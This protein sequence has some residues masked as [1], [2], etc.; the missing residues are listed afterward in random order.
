MSRE[1]KDLSDSMAI[2]SYRDKIINGPIIRMLLWLGAP[3]LLNQLI[4]MAYNT[5]D[6]YWLSLCSDLIVAVPRQVWPIMMLFQALLNALTAA[7]LSMTSQYI[8]GKAYK[9]ASHSV[10][11][12]FTISFFAGGVLCTIL[13][14]LR[15]FI[16]AWM[17]TPHEIFEDVMRYS[18]IIAFDIFLNY[19]SLTFTTILQSVGDTKRPAMINA[20]SVSLNMLLDPFLVLGLGP[21][22]RLGVIGASITDVMG[23]AISTILLAYI[24]RRNYP[25]LKITFTKNIDFKW[26]ILVMH[27]SLPVLVLG[28]TNSFAFLV[29]LKIVNNLGLIAATAYA[30]GFIIMDIVDGVLFGLSGATAIMV[31]QNLGAR[32]IDRAREVSY[33]SALL[34]F[35]LVA[36]GASII[37]PVRRILADVFADDPLIIAETERFLQTLLPTLPFFGLF[38]VAMSTG[39]GSGHTLAPTAIGI[40]RLWGIRIGLGYF[41]AFT[42]NMGPLGAWLAIASSNIVGGIASLLWI[43]FGNWAKPVIKK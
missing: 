27:I 32:K 1:H 4:I 35:A 43:K 8:G 37:Y 26:A 24:I 9:E 28:L 25:E 14:A 42:L 6:A 10:S 30:I 31:G 36:L 15:R 18:G 2:G 7:S 5:M 41:L 22:P 21:F 17:S 19:I 40:F 33:K 34:I 20:A 16:F 29:Q 38:M 13:L 12:F 3:P 39:R 11:R 23:K